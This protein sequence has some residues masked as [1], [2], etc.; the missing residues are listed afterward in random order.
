MLWSH[1]DDRLEADF[2]LLLQTLQEP[3]VLNPALADDPIFYFVYSPK[4][5]LTV[6]RLMPGWKARLQ[7]EAGLVVEE[8]SLSEV[9]WEIVDESGRWEEWLELEP[10]FD[11]QELNAAVKDA[12]RQDNA[13][14]E[15]VA[16]QA[17]DARPNTVLF[18]T[19]VE[20]LHPTF[21]H[22]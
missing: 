21:V 13:L 14:V 3:S 18:L 5:A 17:Q 15:R 6:R 9:I 7:N 22:A 2:T 4:Q 11:Q 10:D 16:R 12:L 8:L 20:L 1:D 19:D